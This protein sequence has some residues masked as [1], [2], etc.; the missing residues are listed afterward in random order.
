MFDEFLETHVDDKKIWEIKNKL[1]TEKKKDSD[2]ESS[3]D[4]DSENELDHAVE[5]ENLANKNI[6]DKEYMEL[7]KN[8]SK[9]EKTTAVTADTPKTHGPNNFFT[10]KL[11]GLGYN[12]KKKDI[13]I[14]FKGIK[15]KSIRVPQKIKGIAFVGFKTLKQMNLA[16]K[17][18]KSFLGNYC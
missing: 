2:D 3:E 6:S 5:D 1:L 9:S 4:E 8:K 10:V 16:L 15:P 17:K 11:K 14:F 13:K 18:D 7:L 12:H